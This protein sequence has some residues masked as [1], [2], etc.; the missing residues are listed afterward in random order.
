MRT[1][2]FTEKHPVDLTEEER[3]LRGRQ[4]ARLSVAVRAQK[5]RAKETKKKLHEE[6]IQITESL[7]SSADAAETGV[8][9]REI[10]CM[11]VL[12][13]TMVETVRLDTHESVGARPATKEELREHEAPVRVPGGGAKRTTAP[14]GYTPEEKD[15]KLLRLIAEL[16]A[17]PRPESTLLKALAKGVPEATENERR[18]AI[19]AAMERAQL[20]EVDGKL[21]WVAPA[22]SSGAPAEPDDGVVDDDYVPPQ[23]H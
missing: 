9:E 20:V 21:A 23:H 8:E 10:E 19:V 4:A 22:P 3:N 14:T 17:K 1:G 18:I 13:G 6:E 11:E 2:R 5:E 7:H 15:A 16:C 12:R